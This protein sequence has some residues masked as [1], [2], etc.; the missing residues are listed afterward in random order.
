[1]PVNPVIRTSQQWAENADPLIAQ[2]KA[3][4]VVESPPWSAAPEPVGN[5]RGRYQKAPG[6]AATVHSGTP[7]RTE[8]IGPPPGR[9]TD[10]A[11]GRRGRRFKS[12][13]PDQQNALSA[14]VQH[15]RRWVGHRYGQE[16]HSDR[17]S[18]GG[19]RASFLSA[20]LR[21]AGEECADLR[22]LLRRQWPDCQHRGV[23]TRLL[24]GADPWQR[25]DRRVESQ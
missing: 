25:D 14:T 5:G 23:L 13:H 15:L 2:I 22:C 16:C 4:D 12:C 7:P 10:R 21:G 19:P 17:P 8:S 11:S 6:R 18:A 1:M 3:S 20:A 24:L 9:L